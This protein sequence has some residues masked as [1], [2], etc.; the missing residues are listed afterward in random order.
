[1]CGIAAIVGSRR[2]GLRPGLEAAL[3]AMH[4]R[5]PDSSGVHVASR[6]LMGVGSA[7]LAIMDPANGWQPIANEAGTVHVVVNGEFYDGDRLRPDLEVRG[8]RFRSKSDSE[9]L[10]HL[11]EEHGT[12][13]LRFLKGEFAFAVL[14]ETAD[15]LFVATDRFGIKPL[16][17][18]RLDG[19]W[20]FASEAKGLFAMGMPAR[21][22]VAVLEQS[23]TLQYPRPGTTLFDGVRLLRPAY[24]AV[25][26]HG[27]LREFVYWE[28]RFEPDPS[29]G[30]EAVAAALRRAVTTR[31][32]SDVPVACTLSGGLDSNAVAAMSGVCHRF[33]VRFEG[34]D[35]DE[36]PLVHEDAVEGTIVH[37]VPVSL[38]DQ[39]VQLEPAIRH[40]EGLAINGQ[41]V[42]KFLLSRAI[43]DAGFKV[44]LAGE[45]ADEAFLGYAHLQQDATGVAPSDATQR[46]IMLPLPD[47][48]RPWRVPSWIGRAPAFL[49]AKLATGRFAAALLN[50]PPEA[51]Q[52][53]D[54]WLAGVTPVA[55]P[56]VRRAAW[57]WTRT[58]LAGYILRTLGDG[59]EMAHSVEAR[60]P[61]LD[62]EVFELAA[63][64]PTEALVGPAG[65]KL[66]LREAL[67]GV[68]PESIRTRP[69]HPFLAP[70]LESDPVVEAFIGDTVASAD[71]RELPLFDHEAVRR[72]IAGRAR[73]A[74]AERRRLDPVLMQLLTAALLQR[75]FRLT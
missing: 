38:R 31:L 13:C 19:S 39:V 75:C 61:F 22:D 54:G 40:G 68:I 51:Q 50:R 26:E 67:R 17:F 60:L 8:H 74:A 56:F 57:L 70:P 62:H 30:P 44:V 18:G 16:H 53:L 12:G 55:G 71:C 2:D 23:L 5:G 33:C 10:V 66:A 24:A 27:D 59:A 69:K 72:W 1:V 3:T 47:E 7:R 49:Q 65:T 32:R 43:R 41:L 37:E 14:D 45:G 4:H 28:P 42:G 21:W 20:L 64:L 11:Y 58:A 63:A 25:V 35:Y 36:G 34:A 29:L 52:I 48:S 73:L 15:R 6:T 9:L 46:G